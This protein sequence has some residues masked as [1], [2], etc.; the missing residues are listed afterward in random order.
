MRDFPSLVIG[1]TRSEHVIS[2]VEYDIIGEAVYIMLLCTVCI[3][4]ALP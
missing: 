3:K 4:S 1:I 2:D